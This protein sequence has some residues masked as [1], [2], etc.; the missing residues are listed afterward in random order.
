MATRLDGLMK[1]LA[2][3]EGLSKDVA[4]GLLNHP[5]DKA[6]KNELQRTAN[7]AFARSLKL[8][9]H[10]KPEGKNLLNQFLEQH[11]IRMKKKNG[12]NL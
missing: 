11:S 1:Y 5:L 3:Y 9:E 12:G 7:T 4:S 10:V 6:V 8:P 2:K